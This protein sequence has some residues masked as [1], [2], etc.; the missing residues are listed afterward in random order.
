MKAGNT[1]WAVATIHSSDYY[2]IIQ[3]KF[4]S[5]QAIRFESLRYAVT[6]RALLISLPVLVILEMKSTSCGRKLVV[7]AVMYDCLRDNCIPMLVAA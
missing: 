5:N 4:V 3:L 1:L 6:L 7:V 2:L